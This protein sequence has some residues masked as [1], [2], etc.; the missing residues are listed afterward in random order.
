MKPTVKTVV[1]ACFA[2][3]AEARAAAER[4]ETVGPFA[5]D[6]EIHF[7]LFLGTL[8]DG[9]VSEMEQA[10][11]AEVVKALGWSSLHVGLL[12]D[13]VQRLP[14]FELARLVQLPTHPALARWLLRLACTLTHADGTLLPIEQTFLS[15]LAAQLGL[16]DELPDLQA[17]AADLW[18][19]KITELPAVTGES[20]KTDE[21]APTVEEAMAEL[22]ALVGLEPVKAEVEKLTRF[23]EIQQQRQAHDLPS[24]PLTLHLVFSGNPGT[25]KTT[26]AR[27]LAKVFRALGVLQRGHLVET[28]RSGLVGQY[29]GHTAVKADKVIR[30]ALDGVLFIDEAYSLLGEG[31]DFGQ[32]AIDTLVK[33]MEDARDRLVV[34]VAGYTDEMHAFIESNPGLR[35]RFS[36]FVEFPDYA[37]ADLVAIFRILCDKNGYRLADGAAERLEASLA[38]AKK[39]AGRSFGNARTVRN[40]F[41]QAL[42]NQ[43]MRLAAGQSQASLTRDALMELTAMDVDPQ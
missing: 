37:P 9:D 19:G 21:P 11:Q 23:L 31:N 27:I 39:A 17:Q 10:F 30:E 34:I 6:F 40:R 42:R 20:T 29:V 7:T 28:D 38:A 41:E 33:R 16:A 26:V 5:L 13:K 36:H 32:E 25:G 35:S 3:Y 1:D 15:T 12:D 24:P 14:D 18:A 43:A 2:P 22:H 4:V 8:I